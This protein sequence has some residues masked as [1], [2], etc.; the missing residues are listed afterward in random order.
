M[1]YHYRCPDMSRIRMRVR[2][3]LRRY[4]AVPRLR[5][6]LPAARAGA[7]QQL[8]QRDREAEE[9]R[10]RQYA[11]CRKGGPPKRGARGVPACGEWR[12]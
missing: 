3:V 2:P 7:A 5:R 12:G 11:W 8:Q 4:A 6:G 1:Y 10:K 9:G